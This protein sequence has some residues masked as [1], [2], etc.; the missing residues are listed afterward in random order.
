MEMKNLFKNLGNS[1]I[2]INNF[3]FTELKDSNVR[4]LNISPSIE[5]YTDKSSYFVDEEIE[6]KCHSIFK[7]FNIEF[8]KYPIL[9][10]NNFIKNVFGF[11]QNNF[12]AY[13]NGASWKTTKKFKS[14]KN[15]KSGLYMIKLIDS[16]SEFYSIVIKDKLS[17]EIII[18]TPS[19]TWQ[20]YND[21]GGSSFYKT[22]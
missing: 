22:L 15:W 17:K 4:I 1:K 3:N 19:I 16:K 7:E 11:K 2:L 10:K 8:Y 13:L 12:N 9:D 14:Q 18:L 5:G 6:I 20:A 21:W